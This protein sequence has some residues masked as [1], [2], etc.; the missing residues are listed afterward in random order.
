MQTAAKCENSGMRRFILFGLPI[1]VLLIA[2]LGYIVLSKMESRQMPLQPDSV[3]GIP[4]NIAKMYTTARAMDPRASLEFCVRSS[5]SAYLMKTS[6]DSDVLLSY[7]DRSGKVVHSVL[8]KSDGTRSSPDSNAIYEK[9]SE[10]SGIDYLFPAT[11]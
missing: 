1:G 10:C 8:Q 5:E 2:A 4:A 3:A 9:Y 7:F 11:N 6:M